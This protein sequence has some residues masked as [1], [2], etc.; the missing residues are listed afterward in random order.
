MRIWLDDVRDAPENWVRVYTPKE[1]INLL[2]KKN[3]QEVS[4]DHDLSNDVKG[5]GYDVLLWIEEQVYTTNYKPPVLRVH[6]SNPSARQKMELAIVAIENMYRKK[7][8]PK[9]TETVPIA[10]IHVDDGLPIIPFNQFAV[11]V[12]IIMYDHQYAESCKRN[13][14]VNNGWDVSEAHYG[15]T[16]SRDGSK[17]SVYFENSDKTFDFECLENVGE[18]LD[19]CPVADPVVYW[20]YYPTIPKNPKLSKEVERYIAFDTYRE[21]HEV[22][23]K[24]YFEIKA[25]FD[26]IYGKE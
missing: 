7:N 23:G 6:S 11:S 24:D 17:K 1:C 12:L 8:L 13:G 14:W 16:T 4:L 9:V 22:E 26:K 3:V 15:P 21:E 2:K 18:G 20:A 10:W 19:W 25:E 5:T